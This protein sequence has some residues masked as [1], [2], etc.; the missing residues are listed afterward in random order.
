MIAILDIMPA[1]TVFPY[2]YFYY[3]VLIASCGLALA[4]LQRSRAGW[5]TPLLAPMLVIAAGQ[6]LLLT[7]SLLS[8]QGYPLFKQIF[9]LALRAITAVN[10]IWL[11]WALIQQAQ[12]HFGALIP[13]ALSILCLLG[14]GLMSAYWLPNA[15]ATPLNASWMDYLWIGFSLIILVTTQVFLWR[16]SLE[17]RWENQLILILACLGY[18]LHLISPNLGNLPAAVMVSQLIYYPLLISL[19]WHNP[20]PI[21]PAGQTALTA[22]RPLGSPQLAASFL[23]VSLQREQRQLLRALT[24]ALG[25]YLMADLTFLLRS[26][27]DKQG[28]VTLS[29][30]DLIREDFL[31]DLRFLEPDFPQVFSHLHALQP[32]ILNATESDQAELQT[33]ARLTGYNQ[34][35]NLLLF[36]FSAHHQAHESALLCLSP[37]TQRTWTENDIERL[38]PLSSHLDSILAEAL[39]Q[40]TN[41]AEAESFDSSVQASEKEKIELREEVE[42]SRQLLAQMQ[43]E[44]QHYQQEHSQEVQLWAE[45]QQQLEDELDGLLS[46]TKEQQAALQEA[47]Q[48]R[49]EKETLELAL[50]KNEQQAVQLKGALQRMQDALA[51]I[52]RAEPGPL[53]LEADLTTADDQT[54]AGTSNLAHEILSTLPDIL[55]ACEQRGLLLEVEAEKI[56]QL[57]PAEFDR[58][59]EIV[60]CL[61]KNACAASPRGA[62]VLLGIYR[63]E[64]PDGSKSIEILAT[65]R[66]GGISQEEQRRFLKTMCRT[67]Y[68]VPAGVGDARALR[69]AAGL[70]QAAGGHW[71]IHSQIGQPTTYRVA[72][73]AASA[74]SD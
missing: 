60:A 47:G 69:E 23:D 15:E 4:A 70:V 18:L 1:L 53:A 22:L 29:G 16:Q 71:W 43:A 57:L 21:A 50:L 10:L 55:A 40:T 74:A 44:Y 42:K 66:G 73:P 12:P 13:G 51:D 17:K 45:R 8:Y 37:Y 27:E 64:L 25:L 72:V 32:L 61:M 63:G 67:G 31:A 68:P 36:P 5:T 56:V 20:T 30:Y 38:R 46:T 14:A 52:T 49:A 6:L 19:S 58:M 3:F 24:R 34:T 11:C 9:P 41:R 39:D 59:R 54:E 28:A 65:D 62:R 2:A 7:L 26:E 48:L 35:G 33:A